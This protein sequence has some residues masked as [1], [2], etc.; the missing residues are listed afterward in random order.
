VQARRTA[1][2]S[3]HHD[4]RWAVCAPARPHRVLAASRENR[5][6]AR[7]E[8]LTTREIAAR[9][10]WI[11]APGTELD[12][13]TRALLELGAGG[14]VLFE[15]NIESVEQ[16]TQLCAAARNAAAGPLRI[17]ID[18]E[19]GH[20][21]RIREPL[22]RMPSLMAIG[23]TRSARLAFDVA[24]A[25]ATDLSALG[26]DTVLGPVLDLAADPSSL[27]VG[28]RSFGSAP[29]LVGRLG[30]A[31]I[32]GYHAGGLLAVGKHFPGHGRTALDSH[33]EAPI[34][35]ASEQEL[36]ASD[37]APYRSAVE[38]GVDA[39][40]TSH[41]VYPALDER[42]ATL[43]RA[44][45]DG[46]A[47]RKLGYDG[48][49]LTD[50]LVMDAIAREH[51]VEGAALAALAAGADAV[52]PLARELQ[53]LDTIAAGIDS[54]QLSA[55]ETALHLRRVARLDRRS[56]IIGPKSVVRP[57]SSAA[58]AAR[59]AAR[60]LTLVEGPAPRL[61][62]ADAVLLLEL[63]FERASPVEDETSGHST[64]AVL[65]QLFPRLIHVRLDGSRIAQAAE[66]FADHLGPALLL[67]RDQ[68]SVSGLRQ[69]CVALSRNGLLIHVAMRSPHDLALS[70]D[71]GAV[72]IG[73]YSDTPPTVAALGSALLSG[74]PWLGRLPVPT[75][76]T[77]AEVATAPAA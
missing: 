50:G 34:V 68:R 76:W 3:P 39:I 20:I 32:E 74:G 46:I 42:P 22:E 18:Q 5:L 7:D 43:S 55:K 13:A 23:A 65:A 27:V 19:G 47:R 24:R 38:V 37:L 11:T 25:S 69:L 52:M 73:A 48:L 61:S 41:C 75:S 72:R 56:R 6:T 29:G 9:L 54:G 12:E 44:V 30:A 59:V 67:T 63:P 35:Q 62:A 33:Y 31:M 40:M 57:V 16:V 53:V 64:A 10:T 70:R 71:I 60:A 58:V 14:L 8:R 45:L 1:G 17:A 26:I 77:T 28:S 36:L 2:R 21:V 66:T 15:R 4:V 49:L 51:G